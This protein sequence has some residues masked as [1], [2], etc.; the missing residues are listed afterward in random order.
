MV[1]TP[2]IVRKQVTKHLNVQ[3][4]ASASYDP[5]SGLSDTYYN[6]EISWK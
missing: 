2:S 5:Y 4:D 6:T 1:K 3:V